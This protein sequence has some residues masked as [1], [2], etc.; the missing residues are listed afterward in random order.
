MINSISSVNFQGH[1]TEST[2][3][4]AHKNK[5]TNYPN[6]GDQIN[7]QGHGTESTGSIAHKNKPTNYPNC[8]SQISF[9]DG[10]DY[11]DEKNGVSIGAIV[12]GLVAISAGVLI[13]LGYADKVNAFGKLNKKGLKKT[14]GKIEPIAKKCHNLCS[15]IKS[16]AKEL[17]NKFKNI[18]KLN[19]F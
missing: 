7:F 18:L 13:G 2:G 8:D 9:C 11:C 14:V 16:K 12:L 15:K 10:Y 4:I 1:G 5:P 19:K 17:I 6:Y 3:S